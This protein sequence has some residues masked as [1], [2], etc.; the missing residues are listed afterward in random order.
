MLTQRIAIMA[1]L[2][3][4]CAGAAHPEQYPSRPIR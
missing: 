4:L 2:A 3:A 1:A